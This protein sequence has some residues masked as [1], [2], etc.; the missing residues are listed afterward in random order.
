M[1][2]QQVETASQ[3][4]ILQMMET[5]HYDDI[6]NCMRCGFCL[7]ACPTYRE[8]GR[9]TA[10]PRGRIAM[11][12][13]VA[14]GQLDVSEKFDSDMYFCL[15]CRACETACPAGVPYGTL[16]EGA[17]EVVEENRKRPLITRIIR[18]VAMKK[19]IP[20]A[21]RMEQVSRLLY[22]YQRSGLRRLARSSGLMKLLP[23]SMAEME[24]AVPEVAS[25][26]A[27]KERKRMLPAKGEKRLTVGLFTGCVM[28]V[29]FFDTN[30]ATAKLLSA[31]GCDVVYM[32]GQTCCGAL[33]AH[34]GDKQE[35]K[36]LAKQNIEAF[37]QSGIDVLI[38]NA[39]GCGAA[40]KEYHHWFHGD[41]EWEERAERF[42]AAQRDMNELLATLPV[43]KMRSLP[44]RVT[45]QDSCHLAHGQKIRLQPRELIQSIPGIEYVELPEADRCCG[46]AGIYNLTNFD[47]SMQILDGKMK[48][49]EG[50]KANLVVTSNPGCLLQMRAG[51]QRAGLEGQMRAVHIADLLY[52]AV[53]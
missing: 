39:G 40:L 14:T 2:T 43:P 44:Y 12:K 17:R 48:Q 33:H 37:E 49:V 42:V 11:M 16:L 50:T 18:H 32:E 24:K 35:A 31:F 8:T 23:K 20:Q 6:L 22:F 41:P 21:K 1:S 7:S 13:A 30:E 4:G 26:A 9:E 3:N 46:S 5:M 10:S 38:N 53:E 34:A 19:L 36:Q 27:R 47:M 15:G 28:D 51:I 45:Y 29:M 52:E 25:P